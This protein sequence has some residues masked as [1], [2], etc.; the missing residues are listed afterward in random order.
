MNPE[1]EIED[2]DI[3]S[4]DKESVE[5][6]LADDT[7][8]VASSK[9][10]RP[11]EGYVLESKPKIFP[12]LS[13]FV[14][15]RVLWNIP[16]CKDGNNGWIVSEV[17]GGPPDPAAAARGITVQLRC[18]SRFNQNTPQYLLKGRANAALSLENYGVLWYIIS[19]EH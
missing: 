7:R 13:S 14:H 9:I 12:S 3:V 16:V 1:D 10:P 15:K 5:T 17:F 8:E 19:Q 6:L 11:P 18:S 2:D 4:F